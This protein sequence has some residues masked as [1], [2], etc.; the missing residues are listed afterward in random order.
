M[1]GLAP[2]TGASERTVLAHCTVTRRGGVP[3]GEVVG[4]S[5]SLFPFNGKRARDVCS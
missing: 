4:T 5:P 1:V 2:G 3:S